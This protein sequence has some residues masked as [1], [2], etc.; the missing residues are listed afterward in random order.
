[1]TIVATV[2]ICVHCDRL[3][4]AGARK[5]Y[6][7]CTH[8]ILSGPALSR[9]NASH[10]EKV[11]VTNT[12]PQDTNMK[13]CQK[14]EVIRHLMLIISQ[15]TAKGGTIICSNI[16]MFINLSFFSFLLFYIFLSSFTDRL[17]LLV[18]LHYFYNVSVNEAFHL[19]CFDMILI[20]DHNCY[21]KYIKFFPDNKVIKF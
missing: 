8:G 20:V 17:I 16:I 18:E 13:T 10:F 5:I 4:E 11:V 12:V 1:M 14:L 6:A 2:H 15:L 7:I 21:V 9:V 19:L 3:A